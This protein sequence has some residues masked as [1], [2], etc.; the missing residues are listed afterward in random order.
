MSQDSVSGRPSRARYDAVRAA[1]DLKWRRREPQVERMSRELVDALWD[2]FQDRGW[3]WCG[4]WIIQPD[5][6]G[7]QPGP[8]RP[9]PEAARPLEG[10][11]AEAVSTRRT[12][13][14]PGSIVVPVFDSKDL[15]WAVFEARSP[16]PFDEMDA[17]WLEKLFRIFYFIEK[18]K[19][20]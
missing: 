2:A 15:C 16:A 11:A 7:L 6:A 5:G 14:R 9:E 13:A 4:L 20:A 1:L 19:D 12:L 10:P 17:R 3:S 8:S 18:R